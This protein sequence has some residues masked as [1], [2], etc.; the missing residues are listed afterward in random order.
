MTN[1]EVLQK[2]DNGYRM[3]CPITC[4]L[5][6]YDIMLECWHKDPDCRPTFETLEWKLEELFINQD[7]SKYKEA[8]IMTY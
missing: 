6:L 4:P 1:A 8:A 2:I 7:G 3:N 5:T